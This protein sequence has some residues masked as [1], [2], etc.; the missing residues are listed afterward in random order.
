MGRSLLAIKVEEFG[1]HEALARHLGPELSLKLSREWRACARPEQLAPDGDWNTWL[2][3]AGRGWG[4]TRTGAEWC[5]AEAESGRAKRIALIAPTASDY[6]DVMIEGNS[7]I[8]SLYAGLPD[9]QRPMFEPTKRRLTWPNGAV[10]TA[11]TAEEPN[12]LRGPQFDAFWADEIAAWKYPQDTWDQLQFGLRLGEHPRGV[13]T[14]TPRPIALVRALIANE[15]VV[16]TR[17]STYD[18]ADNLAASFLATIKRAYEGTR[19]GRQE[20]HAEVLDDNPGALWRA[21]G[22]DKDRVTNAPGSMTRVAVGVDPAGSTN[23]DSDETGI[24]YAGVAQCRCKGTAELHGFVLDDRS[25]IYSPDG[26]AKAVA[27]GYNA[28]KCDRVV[29]EKNFGGDL[30]M[31]NLRTLG[32]SRLAI[33]DVS[34]S[35]GKVIRAEP[36]AALYEQGKVH[37]VGGFSKLEDQM[38][39]WNPLTDK[40]S[41]DRLDA[42][43]WALTDLMLARSS[44][45]APLVIGRRNEG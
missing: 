34:A 41:P 11:F 25:G 17:G 40:K 3:L 6:R 44:S 28:H 4:K 27:A 16:V 43:V 14:T 30:V 45:Y 22:I 12:R 18:N 36:V 5:K 19:L 20:I 29:V 15:S 8:L 10:A 39:Q 33:R 24:V 21:D 26:W 32:D 9:D 7:G 13:V 37:H 35:R 1:G 2:C 23:A 38:T 31:S 42:L